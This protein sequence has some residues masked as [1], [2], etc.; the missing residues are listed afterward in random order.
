GQNIIL[1]VDNAPIHSLYKNTY[2]TNI[3]IEYFPL[4]TT[5]YLQLYNQG[6]INSFKIF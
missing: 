3:I 5:A 1:L 4:N 2:L 6:I